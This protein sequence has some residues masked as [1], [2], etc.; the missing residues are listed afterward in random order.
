M[1]M[2]TLSAS[3]NKK[4][5]G[6]IDRPQKINDDTKLYYNVI[7]KSPEK[8]NREKHPNG[9]HCEHNIDTWKVK[10]NCP[11]ACAERITNC[12]TI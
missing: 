1:M 7:S 12:R 3:V 5:S 8:H 6:W 9:S 4:H 11:N 2:N 10:K